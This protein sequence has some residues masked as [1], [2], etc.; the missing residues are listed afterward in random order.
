[1][2]RIST[3]HFATFSKKGS[4][5]EFQREFERLQN[6]VEGWTEKA[7]VGAFMGGLHKS[8]SSGIRIFK[9]KT[10]LEISNLARLRDDQLQQEKR[11]PNPRPYQS[12]QPQS[13]FRVDNTGSQSDKQATVPKRL[14]WEELKKKRSL[15]LC[16][17]CDER[18]TPGHRCKQPQLFI[19]EV[20]DEDDTETEKEELAD[21]AHSPEITLHALTGWDAP[22][23]IR[24]HATIKS[25]NLL[26]LVD[27]SSTH[28]FINERVAQNLGLVETETT[29]FQVLVANGSPLQC[30]RMYENVSLKLG[31]TRF[32]LTLY[33]LPLVGLDLVMGVQWLESRGPML[34]DWKAQTLQFQWMGHTIL[35]NGLR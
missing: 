12:K 35:L 15:G 34:C 22:T 4:L 8:I 17:S 30:R 23:T 14:S 6:K 24:L 10:L 16:F 29:P 25:Q 27:S 26:A 33:A 18:Y 11:W 32:E 5:L 28:N 21:D 19:M 7:L 20:G 31:E 2:V 1:M 3:K 9:H 13:N